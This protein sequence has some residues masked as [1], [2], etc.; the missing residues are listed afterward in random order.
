MAD[1]IMANA[2]R[3]RHDQIK[4]WE[5]SD[6]NREPDAP[7]LRVKRVKFQDGCVFLAACSSGDREEVKNLLERGADI[8]TANVDGLTALHQACIDDNLD[9][10][11]FL[12]E[13]GAD[14]D[15]CDNEGWTPLH[16]TA[17]CGFTE[18]AR[19]L[20]KKGANVAAVNND[21]DLAIDI[22]ED[23][24]MEKLLQEEMD[25]KGVNA[26]AAR[27]E[28]ENCMLADAQKW[29]G[30]NNIE[31]KIH[32]KTGATALHVAAAKGYINVMNLLLQA[33]ANVNVQDN[34]GWTPLHAAVHW[35]QEDACQNLVEHMCN[36]DIKNNAGHTAFDLA[37]K[38]M[39]QL[40]EE[41]KKKQA[42]M[43]SASGSTS[44][45]SHAP[46]HISKR[47]SS[48]TRMSSDQKQNVIS[49][50]SEEERATLDANLT[51]LSAHKEEEDKK[52]A[53]IISIS[54]PNAETERKNE[55]NKQ[56]SLISQSWNN[57]PPSVSGLET[58]KPEMPK[59]DEVS[60]QEKPSVISTSSAITITTIPVTPVT[61][62]TP[63]PKTTPST[64]TTPTTPSVCTSITTTTSTLSTTP[65]TLE[66]ETSSADVTLRTNNKEPSLDERNGVS[67]PSSK[68][69]VS[70]SISVP[71][72]LPS[73]QDTMRLSSSQTSTSTS[74]EQE[75][76]S[77]RRGI[78]KT[79]STSMVHE[80]LLENDADKSLPRSASSPRLALDYRIES[81]QE[82]LAGR[83]PL[84]STSAVP[85]TSISS[86]SSSSTDSITDSRPG[87]RSSWSAGQSSYTPY[88]N[89]SYRSSYVP[90]YMRKQEQN[91]QQ[92][93]DKGKAPTSSTSSSVSVPSTSLPSATTITNT[94]AATTTA[95]TTVVTSP[96]NSVFRRSFEPPKRDE[97]TETQ[98]KARAKH[99][100][101]TRRSTQGVDLKDIEKAEEVIRQGDTNK[102]KDS[103]DSATSRT[104]IPDLDKDSK[105]SLATATT[106]ASTTVSLTGSSLQTDKER[107]RTSANPSSRNLSSREDTTG[108]RRRNWEDRVDGETIRTSFRRPREEKD[109]ASNN[110]NTSASL[111][112]T[113]SYIP[114]SQRNALSA[115]DNS[116]S[117]LGSSSN[118][119]RSSSLRKLR[120]GE[121]ETATQDEEQKKDESK[122]TKK[123]ESPNTEKEEKKE[124]SAIRARRAR[125]ERRSTGINYVTEGEDEKVNK[126]NKPEDE[127]KEPEST[128]SRYGRYSSSDVPPTDSSSVRNRPVSYSEYSRST[129]TLDADYKKLYEEEKEENGRLKK[130]LE[131]CKKE[132][133][134]AKSELDKV[135]KRTIDTNDKR[136]K[137]ALERKVSEYEEE[138]KQ[139]EKVKEEN[140]KLKEE[141]RALSRVVSKLSR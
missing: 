118:I 134:E 95:S 41:L 98:R 13:H 17:S 124:P 79:G 80:Q 55:L 123:E 52:T 43:R 74:E 96:T 139:M 105:S 76:P 57:R 56:S 137:R 97:E 20:L 59:I 141:N 22:A 45:I 51:H 82:R 25:K 65:S 127:K 68:D 135:L 14:V 130:E 99:A 11:E 113:S 58:H 90:Y 138:L 129:G 7:K 28:E 1:D 116:T 10:V 109:S 33:G 9:M 8:N 69:L 62:T 133:L 107:D 38:E 85:T 125:R 87:D 6:T 18:I 136:E 119:F 121:T 47:R 44:E 70:R 92:E 24:E 32:P 4:R 3:T 114:R 53:P 132:L 88:R 103:E 117:S 64:P 89:Y 40:L 94:A 50:T 120:N 15:V 122:E 36:M 102:V 61:P 19:Y 83:R 35:G 81:L 42:T 31:D 75:V 108:Y 29:L 128:G 140:K 54:T 39:L 2:L 115:S 66:T 60:E 101:Q 26:E 21:G 16:A 112:I 110:N 46:S 30:S 77:W 12:V 48:V 84:S 93:Q 86:L 5:D 111:D 100:R 73:E 23:E 126:E 131:Q 67:K 104:S 71:T 63:A 106:T 78:R 34:D 37:D 27:R 49:K 91:V 72:R